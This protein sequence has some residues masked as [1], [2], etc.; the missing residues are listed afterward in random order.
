MS[1]KILTKEIAEQ[2]MTDHE[3]VE[4]NE[5]TSIE[6]EAAESLSEFPGE[7][8][9]DP[10]PAELYLDGPKSMQNPSF[11]IERL[12]SGCLIILVRLYP[13]VISRRPCLYLNQPL[14]CDKVDIA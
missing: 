1:D 2:F 5:F 13:A 9:G 3:E 11:K 12:L 6:D 14:G 4:L 8:N 10:A 7:I